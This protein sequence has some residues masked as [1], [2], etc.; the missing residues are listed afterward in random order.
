MRAP[1]IGEDLQP[2]ILCRGVAVVSP[3][4]FCL[5]DA[6]VVALNF[7]YCVLVVMSR[8]GS[9]KIAKSIGPSLGSINNVAILLGWHS[10]L[11]EGAHASNFKPEIS[12]E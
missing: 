12:L 4:E 7:L 2:K 9:Q 8:A 11:K 10:A 6:Q 5:N 1:M 3:G